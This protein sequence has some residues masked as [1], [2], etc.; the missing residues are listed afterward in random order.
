M[1]GEWERKRDMVNTQGST[2]TRYHLLQGAPASPPRSPGH[3]TS[4][5]TG[6]TQQSITP[7]HCI[8]GVLHSI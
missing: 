5:A 4:P 7:E 2:F 8:L 3:A 6:V 1:L